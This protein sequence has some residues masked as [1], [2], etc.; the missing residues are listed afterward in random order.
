MADNSSS[1][2]S[3]NDF[4]KWMTKQKDQPSRNEQSNLIGTFVEPRLSAR[5][6]ATKMKSQDSDIQEMAI[7]FKN[8]GGLV[9]EMDKEQNVLIEVDSGTF[10]IPTFF[11]MSFKS[12]F[13]TSRRNNCCIWTKLKDLLKRTRV[14]HFNVIR[15]YIINP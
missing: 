15:D 14:I 8:Y 1:P 11:I 2:F 10:K 9:L 12:L 5:K 4:R 6:T 3:L 13:S 7:D